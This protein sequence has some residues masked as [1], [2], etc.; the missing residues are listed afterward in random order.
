MDKLVTTMITFWYD[1]GRHLIYAA[2]SVGLSLIVM[3]AKL[4]Y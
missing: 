1:N 3:L 4:M 2:V